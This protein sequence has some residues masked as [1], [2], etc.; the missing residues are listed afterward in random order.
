MEG[1]GGWRERGGLTELKSRVPISHV[2]FCKQAI[3]NTSRTQG[4]LCTERK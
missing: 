2:K 4:D 3:V 1:K